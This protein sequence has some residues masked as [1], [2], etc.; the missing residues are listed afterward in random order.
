MPTKR[1][2]ELTSCYTCS[3]PIWVPITDFYLDKDGKPKN[4]CYPCAWSRLGETGIPV[5]SNAELAAD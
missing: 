1:V 4:F 3:A 2:C 5:V